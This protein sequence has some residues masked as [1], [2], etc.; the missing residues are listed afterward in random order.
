MASKVERRAAAFRHT[1]DQRAR[2]VGEDYV[3][4]IGDLIA[5][6]GEARLTDLARHMGVAA[7]TAAKVVA[8]LQTEGLVQNRPYRALFLT[9]E[10]E[11]GLDGEA[12]GY[13]AELARL[14]ARSGTNW[15][16]VYA[17]PSASP[18]GFTH[19]YASIFAFPVLVV[20]YRPMRRSVLSSAHQSPLAP[21][22]RLVSMTW[23]LPDTPS[24]LRAE[25]TDWPNDV[26]LA[27]ELKFDTLVKKPSADS[28]PPL[29][30]NVP[31]VSVKNIALVLGCHS[32]A[33]RS[34]RGSHGYW[35]PSSLDCTYLALCRLAHE[36][37][38]SLYMRVNERT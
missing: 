24:P 2:E 35:L 31:F 1:R 5:E 13:G 25:I 20:G 36:V 10:G 7:P 17:Q 37:L 18:G 23:C 8:R 14:Y 30:P 32:R 9:P 33:S 16:A 3:E 11:A 15:P 6:F 28:S 27:V 38:V 4:M 21:P 12:D 29:M 19:R 34:A 26:S 22:F